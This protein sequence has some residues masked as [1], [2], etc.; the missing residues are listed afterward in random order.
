[1]S[2]LPKIS[3][4]QGSICLSHSCFSCM[5]LWYYDKCGKL[6]LPLKPSNINSCE[7]K[8]LTFSFSVKTHRHSR[9]TS[10]SLVS[11]EVI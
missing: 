10:V 8:T 9:V 11:I 1:M 3:V 5:I 7:F 2:L 6:F 4:L